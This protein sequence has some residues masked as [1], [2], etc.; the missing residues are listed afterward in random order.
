M[1]PH[2][3][4]SPD[5]EKA[6]VQN[7]QFWSTVETALKNGNFALGIFLDVQ[8]ALDNILF[9]SIKR[10]LEKTKAKGNVSDW[11]LHY[12]TTRKLKSNLKGVALIIWILAGVPQ[13]GVLS[14][15]P[16]QN[17]VLNPLIIFLDTLRQLLAFADDIAI[18]LTGF[19]LST[20]RDLGQRYIRV[21]NVWCESNG[22]KLNAIKTQVI[23]VRRKYKIELSRPI[24][25]KCIEIEFC[26]SVKYLSIYL[27]NNL[28]WQ[29]HVNITVKNELTFSLQHGKWSASAGDWAQ[30]KLF[31]CTT[32]SSNLS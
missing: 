8:S 11:I 14:P 23:V 25:L 1:H 20:L 18:I 15:V 29:D 6:A 16:C 3:Q 5:S 7:Q 10:A 28:N 24:K 22:L 9:I 21:C 19:C 12:I 17:I 31:G 13:G 30:T 27:D 2:C 32:R 26:N 4:N